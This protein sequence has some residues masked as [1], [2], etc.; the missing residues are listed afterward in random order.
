MAIEMAHGPAAKSRVT[1]CPSTPGRSLV[2]VRRAQSPA[3]ARV[4]RRTVAAYVED[5]A[6]RAALRIATEGAA[7]RGASLRLLD[8]T[9]NEDIADALVRESRSADL[10]VIGSGPTGSS[11]TLRF[12]SIARSLAHR[13]DCPVMFV[14]AG[15]DTA[16][17]GG[18]VCGVDRSS[19]SAAALRWAAREAAMRGGTVLAQQVQPWTE[20]DES[21]TQ[22]LSG[23]VVSQQITE[24]TTIVCRIVSGAS[25][26]GELV[27]T[28]VE[29]QGTLVV[30]SHRQ[31][32]GHLHRCI[33][34]RLAG[35]TPV[36]LVVVPPEIPA[37]RR[38]PG[39]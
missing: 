3:T 6:G 1:K 18:L 17:I 11:N 29:R 28:A 26:A 39:L 14:P 19:G 34:G 4:G 25:P 32:G 20:V 24:P 15:A 21:P 9:E 8:P 2:S 30:G 12:D 7:L 5:S 10:L 38:P 31:D 27:H 37:P 13:A 16:D 36:P 35:H 23:W 33:T 22:S